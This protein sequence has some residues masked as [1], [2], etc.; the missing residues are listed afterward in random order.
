MATHSST[1]AW[2]IPWREEPVGY[3]PWGCRESDMTERLHFHFYHLGIRLVLPT[4]LQH[5][6]YT[7]EY[8]F[9]FIFSK[10]GPRVFFSPHLTLPFC[11]KSVSTFCL[12]CLDLKCSF[13]VTRKNCLWLSSI[14]KQSKCRSV[15]YVE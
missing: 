6:Q 9:F 10:P 8:F 14:Y 4:M 12:T 13:K 1:L 11:F 3:S 15:F 2:R 7:T 5:T